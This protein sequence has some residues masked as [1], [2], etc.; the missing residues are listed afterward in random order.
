M[1]TKPLRAQEKAEEI[2]KHTGQLIIELVLQSKDGHQLW[3]A[4][5]GRMRKYS[6]SGKFIEMEGPPS[7]TPSDAI[8]ALWTTL[9]LCDDWE[10]EETPGV[11]VKFLQNSVVTTKPQSSSPKKM[12]VKTKNGGD[13]KPEAVFGSEKISLKYVKI[14]PTIN[15]PMND[16]YKNLDYYIDGDHSLKFKESL[17][18]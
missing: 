12:T 13:V 4:K 17:G 9:R 16:V 7:D 6:F 10:C 2:K 14:A 3:I 11:A 18:E 5:S 1:S 8:N 15:N